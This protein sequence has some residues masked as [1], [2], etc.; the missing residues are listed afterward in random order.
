MNG[1]RTLVRRR[2][3]LVAGTAATSPEEVPVISALREQ[4][5]A[6]RRRE[7]GKALKRMPHLSEQDAGWIEALTK[8]LTGELLHQPIAAI[9]QRQSPAHMKFARELFG[10]N[11]DGP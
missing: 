10:L 6:L 1:N 11:R 2:S 5:E 3:V 8:S 7:L 9:R 4:A